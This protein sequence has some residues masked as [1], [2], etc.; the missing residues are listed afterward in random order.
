MAA[1]ERP[2]GGA[3]EADDVVLAGC[4]RSALDTANVSTGP[5]RVLDG[6][7]LAVHELASTLICHLR[8]A[9]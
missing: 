6:S 2:G 7:P 4:D 8:S 9:T 5:T 3:D 1:Y